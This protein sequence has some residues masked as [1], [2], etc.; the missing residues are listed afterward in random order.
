M[1]EQKKN[2]QKAEEVIIIPVKEYRR[3]CRKIE[4]LKLV[5][6]PLKRDNNLYNKWW[7]EEEAK[8][9]EL[10][11]KLAEAQEVIKGYKEMEME[12]LG[13]TEGNYNAE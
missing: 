5:I 12:K 9:K 1:E 8:R 10:E 3:L 7:Q 4:K 13:L 11:V 2:E 6:K